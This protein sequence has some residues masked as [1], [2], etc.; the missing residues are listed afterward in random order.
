VISA[1]CPLNGVA[2]IFVSWWEGELDRKRLPTMR[3]QS[4]PDSKSD[5]GPSIDMV[6]PAGLEPATRPL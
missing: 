5:I 4:C 1:I 3:L 6:G 2:T